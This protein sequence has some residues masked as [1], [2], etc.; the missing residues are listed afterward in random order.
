MARD[1]TPTLPMLQAEVVQR[2]VAWNQRT[3]TFG[4]EPTIDVET[5]HVRYFDLLWDETIK[6]PVAQTSDDQ[7]WD[8]FYNDR[9]LRVSRA[10]A[11]GGNLT[12]DLRNA[13]ELELEPAMVG[14]LESH[15]LAE[16]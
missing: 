8:I 15:C 6:R 14:W 10:D 9:S 1:D 3:Q 12:E 13:L 7:I 5:A 11:A 4:D 16:E 2:C